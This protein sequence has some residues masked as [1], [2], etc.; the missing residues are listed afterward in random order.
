MGALAEAGGSPLGY[1]PLQALV[2]TLLVL[3]G[4]G[5]GD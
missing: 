5:G 2:A 4:S 1:Q 3:L